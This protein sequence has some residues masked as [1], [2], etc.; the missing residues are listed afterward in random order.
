[1]LPFAKIFA[2]IFYISNREFDWIQVFIKAVLHWFNL[3][4]KV[5]CKYFEFLN[6]LSNSAIKYIEDFAI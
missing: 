4:I 6:I 1:M 3:N 2:L 5:K